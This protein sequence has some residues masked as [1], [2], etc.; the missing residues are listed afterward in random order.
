MR[1]REVE[2]SAPELAERVRQIFDSR[3]HKTMATLR[4]DGSPRVSGIETQF[5]DGDLI[6]GTMAGSVKAADIR[7]D[8][9]VAFHATSDDPDP[10]DQGSWK[11]DAKISGVAVILPEEE[12]PSQAS[13][14]FRVDIT[15]IVW[16]HLSSPPEYLVIESWHPGRGFERQ[17]RE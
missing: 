7:R 13:G 16:T 1:W 6:S 12:D 11:G 9:R 2:Q 17:I 15:E 8:P 10:D 14:R 4:R 5:V 3:Q